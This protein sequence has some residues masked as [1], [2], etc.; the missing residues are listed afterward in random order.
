MSR[1][2][3]YRLGEDGIAGICD[4]YLVLIF[5]LALWNGGDPVLLGPLRA[6]C[7]SLILRYGSDSSEAP[8]APIAAIAAI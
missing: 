1:S 7:E 6:D 4:R 2:K 3:A 5:A 8:I